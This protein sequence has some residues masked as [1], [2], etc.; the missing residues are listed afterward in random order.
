MLIAFLFATIASAHAEV[1]LSMTFGAIG[2]VDTAGEGWLG[3]YLYFGPSALVEIG[4]NLALIP[5]L[6]LEVSPEHGNW[7]LVVTG[8][9]EWAA[10][11]HVG[12]DLVPSVI[13]DTTGDGTAWILAVGPGVTYLF[14]SGVAAS[15]A[16][17]ANYVVTEDLPLTLNP[18]VQIA[19]PIP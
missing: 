5:Q 4:G 12:I 2:V 15:M 11:D 19:V 3:E 9:L 17:Q 10:S 16:A 13:Q 18:I 8:T 1:P 14:D 6:T 7:G